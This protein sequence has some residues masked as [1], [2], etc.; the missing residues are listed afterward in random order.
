MKE[1]IKPL[2]IFGISLLMFRRVLFGG[3][4]TSKDEQETQE[5]TTEFPIQEQKIFQKTQKEITI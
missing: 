1:F 3:S 5:Q 2:I 4:M